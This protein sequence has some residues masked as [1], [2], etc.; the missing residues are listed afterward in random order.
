MLVTYPC[1]ILHILEAKETG[2]TLEENFLKFSNF[3]YNIYKEDLHRK[4]DERHYFSESVIVLRF[5]NKILL[6]F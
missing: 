4:N 6:P 1:H 2:R 5:R 3:I